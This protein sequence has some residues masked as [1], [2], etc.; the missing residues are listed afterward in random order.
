ML[1]AS[2]GGPAAVAALQAEN[3]FL[4]AGYR[5]IVAT[6]PGRRLRTVHRHDDDRRVVEVGIIG[7]VVLEGPAAGAQAGPSGKPN[8]P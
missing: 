3:P 7:I 1:S 8:R 2:K 6:M 4:G 5:G